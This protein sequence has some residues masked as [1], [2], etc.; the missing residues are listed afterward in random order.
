MTL[1]TKVKRHEPDTVNMH[2]VSVTY[3]FCSQL[4][5]EIDKLEKELIKD[6]ITVRYFDYEEKKYC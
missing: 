1:Y 6:D 4:K 2:S 3:T 5:D